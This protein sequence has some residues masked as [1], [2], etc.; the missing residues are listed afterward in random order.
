MG[1]GEKRG[2][3]EVAKGRERRE[4]EECGDE[5]TGR[6]DREGGRRGEKVRKEGGEEDRGEEEGEER[7]EREELLPHTYHHQ[8]ASIHLKT[9]LA[10]IAVH[11]EIRK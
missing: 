4:E 8:F 11:T 10:P 6:G 9:H 3:E 1:R 2:T 7:E 5:R